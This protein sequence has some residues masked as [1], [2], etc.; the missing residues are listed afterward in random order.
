MSKDDMKTGAG[1]AGVVIAAA[2]IGAVAGILLAPKKGSETRADIKQKVKETKSKSKAKLESVKHKA[3]DSAE[4]VKD[5]AQDAIDKA[6]GKAQDKADD[7]K[8]AAE[9]ARAQ[10]DEAVAEAKIRGRRSGLL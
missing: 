10:A 4:D 8:L 9:K 1:V 3:H 5:K 2:A 7:I 6:S